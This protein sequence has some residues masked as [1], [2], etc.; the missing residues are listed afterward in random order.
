MRS[1]ATL[2]Q[3]IAEGLIARG[4]DALDDVAEGQDSALASTVLGLIAQLARDEGPDVAA[5]AADKIRAAI[6][7]QDAG[8]VVALWG[9]INADGWSELAGELQGAEASAKA[10]ASAALRM[11]GAILRTVAEGLAAGAGK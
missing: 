1:L 6:D 2:L 5:L 7:G 11:A 3:S 10:R 8:A 9:Q 4:A